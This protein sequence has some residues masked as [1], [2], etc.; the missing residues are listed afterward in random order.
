MSDRTR[1]NVLTISGI[2]IL[3]IAV[4]GVSFAFFSYTK[5]GTSNNVITTGQ[6]F[7]SFTDT[8]NIT[9]TNQ[10][11]MLDSEAASGIIA[12]SVSDVT[13][14]DFTVTGYYSAST[15]GINYT[16]YAVDGT[17][18]S[19]KERMDDS[20]INVILTPETGTTPLTNAASSA[21]TL[22]SL[23]SNANGRVLATGKIN[24]NTTSAAPQEDEYTLKMYVNDTV[25]IS[26]TD[27][28]VRF[29]GAHTTVSA[30][31]YCAHERVMSN[32]NYVKGC[33][34]YDNN[35]T[36]TVAANNVAT[37]SINTWLDVYS[38]MYYSLKVKVVGND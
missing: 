5:T 10:F 18:V 35:G 34:L 33:K 26:D 25:R 14:M 9:L 20:E 4:V 17:A 7:L 16:L 19:G 36:L 23:T 11:P 6:I 15:G 37:N 38:D 3:L 2:L 29:T 24:P 12:G 22:T 28:T 21:V 1:K 8:N 30:T 32:G 13:E 31:K 27:T